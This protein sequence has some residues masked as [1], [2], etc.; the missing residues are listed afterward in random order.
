[1]T[2]IEAADNP[3]RL[4]LR[5]VAKLMLAFAALVALWVILSSLFKHNVPVNAR[6]V[7]TPVDV[8]ALTEDSAL[9]IEWFD[10][11][12]IVAR[13]SVASEAMLAA[14]DAD[15][16]RD[17][18]SANSVQPAAAANVYRSGTSGWFVAI[19]I[20]TSSGCALRFDQSGVSAEAGAAFIDQCDGSRYDFAGRA[21]NGSPARKNIP[22]PEWRLEGDSII[23]STA[24]VR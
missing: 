3:R 22:V 7:E 5:V 16:L 4:L 13:R 2:Q 19:G 15:D 11:P 18:L 12:L 23:V 9:L 14:M 6:A 1:M 20:G 21:L 24:P 10:K 17:P 8:T